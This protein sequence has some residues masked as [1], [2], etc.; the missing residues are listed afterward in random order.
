MHCGCILHDYYLSD[1]EE[2]DEKVYDYVDERDVNDG[3]LHVEV[4]VEKGVVAHPRFADVFVED[5][6]SLVKGDE[7]DDREDQEV[8]H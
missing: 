7:D 6:V 2:D 3:Q 1:A 8:L 4:H 5:N